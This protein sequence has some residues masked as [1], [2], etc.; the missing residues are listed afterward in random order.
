MLIQEEL[1]RVSQ[2]CSLT[3]Q[4]GGVAKDEMD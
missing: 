4:R 2:L 3:R 1:A